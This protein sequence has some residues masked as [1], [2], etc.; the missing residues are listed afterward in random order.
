M[1]KCNR[2]KGRVFIDRVFSSYSHLETF[3][4]NC[5]ERKFFHNFTEE[6]KKAQWLLEIEIKRA[7]ASISTL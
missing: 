7:K 3:C 5:G 6:D 4:I 2:C 1:L